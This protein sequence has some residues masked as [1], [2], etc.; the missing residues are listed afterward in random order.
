[1]QNCQE[2][3]KPRLNSLGPV[4]RR[5]ALL[6]HDLAS[7]HVVLFHTFSTEAPGHRSGC[8]EVEKGYQEMR[9]NAKK[10]Q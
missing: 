7:E 5:Q 8:E 9:R 6:G 1:M 4:Q 2:I 10:M 3:D